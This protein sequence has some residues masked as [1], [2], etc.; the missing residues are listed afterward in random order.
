[1][2]AATAT[3]HRLMVVTRNVGDFAQFGVDLLNPFET[4]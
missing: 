1:M 3:V 4:E 2:I